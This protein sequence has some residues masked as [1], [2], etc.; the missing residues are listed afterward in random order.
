M[1]APGIFFLLLSAALFAVAVVVHFHSSSLSLPITP[2]VTILTAILPLVSFFNAYTY[3]SLL[4]NTR[5]RDSQFARLAPTIPQVVQALVTTILATLLFEASVPSQ[6]MSC[7]LGNEWMARFRAHDANTI[8]RVQDM[9]ECCGFNSVK[10]RAYPFPR[11]APSTCADTYGR[12]VAC[13]VP[14]ERAVR[15]SAGVDLGVVLA[16]GLLQI[17]G[18]LMMREGNDWWTAWRTGGWRHVIGGR[19]SSRPL[20]T[21]PDT[22]EDDR[23]E[24][25]E[26]RAYGGTDEEQSGP[27]V[28]PSPIHERNAWNEH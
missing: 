20:L 7:I 19:G 15:V 21:G 14:L 25:S 1:L 22:Q 11:G 5:H 12:T 16:V 3:P 18:L 13:R 28:E 9:L 24:Q 27:R 2:V 26:R 8:R 17:L 10:D 6:A 4:A 23:P